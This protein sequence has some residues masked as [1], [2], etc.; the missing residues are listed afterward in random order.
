MEKSLENLL[1]HLYT[2]DPNGWATVTDGTLDDLSTS[3][4]IAIVNDAIAYV[5]EM[6]Q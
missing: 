1:S 4:K 2:L 3:E 5:I 6:N